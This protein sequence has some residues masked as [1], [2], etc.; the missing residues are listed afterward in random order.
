MTTLMVTHPVADFDTW[1]AAFDAGDVVRRR[2][3]ATVVRVLHDSAGV[4]GL[5]DF[6]D[7]ASAQSFLADPVLRTPVDGVS[8]RPQ[9]RVLSDLDT[10]RG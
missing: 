7:E 9:V 8:Q 3:G 6:P 5:I 1:K 2:H 10:L 4:V